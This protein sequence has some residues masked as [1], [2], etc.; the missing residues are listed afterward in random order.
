MRWWAVASKRVPPTHIYR[1]RSGGFHVYF[2][3]GVGISNSQSKLAHGVD[4]R[5][6]G[7]YVI[8]WF[9]AGFECLDPSPPAPWPVWLRDC[10]LWQPPKPV[11]PTTVTNPKHVDKATEGVLRHVAT[12]REGERNA[13]LYW[14]A[15]RL[16]SVPRRD[17]SA[18]AKQPTCSSTPPGRSACKTLRRGAP[19]PPHGGPR[20]GGRRTRSRRRGSLGR[21]RV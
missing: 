2:Q 7:G 17:R 18:R 11:I 4:S 9:A 10:L 21:H 15:C 16:R 19:Y 12:A 6:D 8:Y 3:H 13:V 14:A 20:D 5:G 1:T